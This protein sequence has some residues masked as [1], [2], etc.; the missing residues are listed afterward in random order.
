MTPKNFEYVAEGVIRLSNFLI[1]GLDYGKIY[2][3]QRTPSIVACPEVI[4]KHAF[5]SGNRNEAIEELI[6]NSTTWD[7][8]CHLGYGVCEIEIDGRRY[9]VD[10]KETYTKPQLVQPLDPEI[11]G[12]GS[13]YKKKTYLTRE[14]VLSN[15]KNQRI[16]K[17][18]V[19]TQWSA[20]MLDNGE[21]QIHLESTSTTIVVK[22][23]DVFIEPIIE[24]PIIT[25]EIQSTRRPYNVN[26]TTLEAELAKRSA[27]TRNYAPV[28]RASSS[29]AT[30]PTN[31]VQ[32]KYIISQDAVL[33]RVRS[34]SFLRTLPKSD[35]AVVN[36]S[37]IVVQ[38]SLKGGRLIEVGIG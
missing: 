36:V 3:R 22:L 5:R 14:F 37:G 2:P 20:E 1:E 9:V 34:D 28:Y 11:Y 35:W 32:E 18:L 19:L 33:S 26:E 25:T 23:D 4:T 7:V 31:I 30:L 12:V 27:F 15:I 21:V 6:A 24:Q 17:T 8:I 16:K 13:G 10:L 38:V 29:V